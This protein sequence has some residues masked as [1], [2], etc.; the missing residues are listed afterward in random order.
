MCTQITVRTLVKMV[1]GGIL[2]ALI[3]DRMELI[4]VRR[5]T[6][7]RM[8]CMVR[9][10]RGQAAGSYSQGNPF[11]YLLKF[12]SFPKCIVFNNSRTNSMQFIFFAFMHFFALSP[13]LTAV[14]PRLPR[15]LQYRRPIQ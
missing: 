1:R 15:G 9:G 14:P 3:L 2:V 12:G 11:N 7:G 10:R 4:L 6:L 13:K 5:G 8:V